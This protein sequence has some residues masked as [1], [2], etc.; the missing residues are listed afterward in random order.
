M[1]ISVSVVIAT[2][3]RQDVLPSCMDSL[4]TQKRLPD[5]VVVIDSSSEKDIT[6]EVIHKYD[7][8]SSI[9][10]KYF[11]TQPGL[12]L[13]RNRGIAESNG[14]IVLF[15][16]DD[17]VLEYDFIQQ[18]IRI[19]ES[20]P[21]WGSIGGIITNFQSSQMHR[22]QSRLFYRRCFRE[23][24]AN[25]HR[26]Q[27]NCGNAEIIEVNS[28]SG[29]LMSFRRKVFENYLF[30]ES[31]PC[32]GFG[33][34]IEFCARVSRRHKIGIALTCKAVHN[35]NPGGR[36]PN[37][38]RI[39]GSLIGYFHVFAV[40]DSGNLI[41]MIALAWLNIGYATRSILK[42]LRHFNIRYIYNHVSM[43]Y[44]VIRNGCLI[45]RQA[46]KNDKPPI[47]GYRIKA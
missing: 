20:Y 41:D 40:K 15:I 26:K 46:K 9:N 39:E 4:L 12:C 33:D 17:V 38:N 37:I 28:L 27:S 47:G 6:K 44:K 30:N 29:C 5:E 43:Q 34:D 18:L 24:R 13:Q 11:H 35:V 10:I 23:E 36:F 14:N 22:L 21:S 16:D 7:N 45:I 8:C 19:Y 2:K 1:G 25:I 31:L 32:G 3:D 42:G